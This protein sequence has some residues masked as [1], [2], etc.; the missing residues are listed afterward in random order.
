MIHVAG[1]DG[2][3]DGWAVVIMEVS[4]KHGAEKSA[5]KGRTDR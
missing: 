2:T 5:V 3:P 4:P 1:V